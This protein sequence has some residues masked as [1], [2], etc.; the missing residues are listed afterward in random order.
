MILKRLLLEKAS[1]LLTKYPVLAITGPR[2][3]GKTTFCKQLCPNYQYLNMELA[4]NQE[5]ARQ[6]PHGFMDAFQG[7]VILDEVQNVPELFPYIQFYTDERRR[8]GEYILSG[9]QHFLLLEKITQSL[10][11]RVALFNLLPFSLEEL[12]GTDW[13]LDAWQQYAWTGF[14]PRIYEAGILPNDFYPDYLQTYVERDVRQI[15]NVSDLNLFKS[16]IASC[17]GRCGQLFKAAQIGNEIGVDAKT[18]RKWLSILETSFIVYRLQ[19]YHKNFSKRIVKT[20]KL[21]FY[22]VGLAAHL[23]GIRSEKDLDVH[24][25]KGALFENMA[26]NELSK[27][28]FNRHE[29]PSFYFWQ[30][31]NSNEI[32]LLVDKITSREIIEIKAGKTVNKSFFSNLEKYK[33]LDKDVTQSWLVYGGAQSQQRLGTN[34]ISWKNL[35]RI[36][37]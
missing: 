18:I 26:I 22:D 37:Q 32:D 23:L 9:S 36:T 1:D 5:Y 19:P 25:A 33:K 10:A 8:Q 3:S 29:R 6:D 14:Y 15:V 24:F 4:D 31:N 21:Y 13:E 35:S 2:Q 17:A 11:G 16:F 7:G 12:K 34:V 30:D 27:N 28:L 20:P